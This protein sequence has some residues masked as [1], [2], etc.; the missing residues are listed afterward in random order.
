MIELRG[1]L[2]AFLEHPF[3]RGLADYFLL[4]VQMLSPIAHLDC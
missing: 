2:R 3:M 4:W 1:G